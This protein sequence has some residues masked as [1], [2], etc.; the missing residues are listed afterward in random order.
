MYIILL[1]YYVYTYYISR[2]FRIRCVCNRRENCPPA[3]RPALYTY[4]NSCGNPIFD[5]TKYT[6]N[7]K[8]LAYASTKRAYTAVYYIL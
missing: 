8:A 2:S 4:E 6:H 7:D 5:R 3:I 1:R